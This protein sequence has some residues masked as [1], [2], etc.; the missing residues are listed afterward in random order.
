MFPS[1]DPISTAFKNAK[2]SSNLLKKYLKDPN[3]P[4]FDRIKDQFPPESIDQ[5][6]IKQLDKAAIDY[7]KAKGSVGSLKKF[8]DF[9]K[10]NLNN[11]FVKALFK[12]PY[13]KSALV[14]GAVLSPTAL[15]ADEPGKVIEE[16][17][18]LIAGGAAAAVAGGAALKYNKEIGA[19]VTGKTDTVAPQSEIKQYAVSPARS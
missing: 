10:K 3:N 4:M 17:P 14:A 13:G 5:D 8:T 18:E 7:N 11:S 2:Y 9:A 1:H 15:M 19:F 6:I 12:T 16:N